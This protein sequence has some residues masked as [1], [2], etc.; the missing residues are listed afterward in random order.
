MLMKDGASVKWADENDEE[1]D[2]VGDVASH[3]NK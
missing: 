1:G 3:N 2:K